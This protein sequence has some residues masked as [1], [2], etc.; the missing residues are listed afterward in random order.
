MDGKGVNMDGKG[1]N[2]DGNR[3]LA[4]RLQGHHPRLSVERDDRMHRQGHEF[5]A[6]RGEFR[7]RFQRNRSSWPP[8]LSAVWISVEIALEF[9]PVKGSMSMP[10]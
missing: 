8:S 2:M 9:G 10:C 7:A 4:F 5:T 6:K 1:V 3:V